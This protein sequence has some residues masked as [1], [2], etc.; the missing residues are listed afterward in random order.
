M[1]WFLIS[2]ALGCVFLC[3]GCRFAGS[4]SGVP[5]PGRSLETERGSDAAGARADFHPVEDALPEGRDEAA[6]SE[7]GG[8]PRTE[9][10]APA[11]PA[12]PEPPK[13]Q[14]ESTPNQKTFSPPAPDRPP[15]GRPDALPQG[16]DAR[17]Q[18]LPAF[19][20][21][22]LAAPPF[23][24]AV[25][26][27][28]SELGGG[29]FRRRLDTAARLGAAVILLPPNVRLDEEKQFVYDDASAGFGPADI[30]APVVFWPEPESADE[31][32]W[33]IL[34]DNE[35]G[36]IILLDSRAAGDNADVLR[37]F[38][39]LLRARKN[40]EGDLALVTDRPLWTT[41]PA[42][43]AELTSRLVGRER[44]AVVAFSRMGEVGEVRRDGIRCIVVPHLVMR[45][46][47]GGTVWLSQGRGGPSVSL[48]RS[49]AVFAI[50]KINLRIREER[51]RLVQSLT[52]TPVC[53]LRSETTVRFQN[54][55]DTPLNV[56]ADWVFGNGDVPVKPE[57]LG[58]QLAPGEEFSQVFR[59]QNEEE[60]PL[61]FLRP[62]FVLS[63]STPDGA[64]GESPL[65]VQAAP[66]CC[67]RG[68][69]ELVD[70]DVVLD[71][72]PSEW[73][74]RGY[75]LNHESQVVDGLDA[76]QGPAD[77]S[78]NLFV[79][80]TADA[81]LIGARIY[82]DQHSDPDRES[83]AALAVAVDLLSDPSSER[84]T[85]TSPVQPD[86]AGGDDSAG[87]ADE[88]GQ[89]KLRFRK[90]TGIRVVPELDGVQARWSETAE[91]LSIEARIPLGLFAGGAPGPRLRLDA[92]LTEESRADKPRVCLVFSGRDPELKDPE[93]F[94]IFRILTSDADSNLEV[95]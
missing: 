89:V 86:S 67:M 64:G 10:V 70:E 83:Q 40:E 45:D 53:G 1:R 36:T 95:E 11:P 75:S 74:G 47:A 62:R 60:S 38:D 33:K 46:E 19:V 76:W 15:Q 55:L 90:Q 69:I 80:R 43:W 79:S 44:T 25:V 73:A 68:V 56:R 31:S 91:A 29:A 41:S 58:F 37:R 5:A 77:L 50:Q 94:G 63:M 3:A 28:S 9:A 78:A 21:R 4:P 39:R 52:V 65:V 54:I 84:T 35:A 71:G 85:G 82:D 42:L 88:R 6:R 27:S 14:A 30:E 12:A 48:L 13:K 57:I 24:L 66:V 59:F 61:K 51:D 7:A 20:E 81:V 16:S 49:D 92:T 22:G 72:D 2:F 18:L 17:R 8:R 87:P 93:L 34:V 23:G 32:E 26:P